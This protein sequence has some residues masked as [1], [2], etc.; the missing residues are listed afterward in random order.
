MWHCGIGLNKNKIICCWSRSGAQY[1]KKSIFKSYKSFI[2]SLSKGVQEIL[3]ELN[4]S[5]I[6]EKGR[7]SYMI[8]MRTTRIYFI[9]MLA[10]VTM[11]MMMMIRTK[12]MRR[13][14]TQGKAEWQWTRF[15]GYD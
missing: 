15:I 5:H 7:G 13:V 2:R 14:L 9:V 3:S 8:M 12:R 11:M 10:M 1:I 6:E 4:R